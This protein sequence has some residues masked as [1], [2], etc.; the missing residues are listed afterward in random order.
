MNTIDITNL[1]EEALGEVL[2]MAQM[3]A[4]VEA[5]NRLLAVTT[6]AETLYAARANCLCEGNSETLLRAA[7]AVRIAIATA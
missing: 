1:S 3:G 2:T 6:N 4:S 7:K 5:I